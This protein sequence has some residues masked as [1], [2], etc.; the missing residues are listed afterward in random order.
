[1]PLEHGSLA[2]H[3]KTECTCVRIF[4][5]INLV[6][7]LPNLVALSLGKVRCTSAEVEIIA[8][9]SPWH[10]V[11]QTRFTEHVTLFAV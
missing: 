10:I 1:M 8:N 4:Y 5:Y 11:A 7:E 3:S 2:A 9:N 6:T